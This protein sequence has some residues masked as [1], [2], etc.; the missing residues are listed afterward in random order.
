MPDVRR[1]RPAKS[2]TLH[3]LAGRAFTELILETFRFNGRLLAAGDRLTAPLGLSS[4]RWQVLGAIEQ[5]P[6]PV[7]QIA[8]NMGVSRQGV[9]RIADSLEAEGI[10]VYSSNPNHERAK[11][12][13]LSQRGVRLTRELTKRQVIWANRISSVAIIEEIES[14]L[15]LVRR[16]RL[17]LEAEEV[18][19]RS[20]GE[21]RKSR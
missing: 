5:R 6:L 20:A 16:L 18:S 12:V 8:R 14:A 9:Q 21:G 19:S 3:T 13:N 15:R 10:V 17:R 1:R 4:A 2:V 11:L 7:A